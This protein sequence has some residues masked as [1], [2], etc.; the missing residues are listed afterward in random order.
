ML[1]SAPS[2]YNSL[3]TFSLV[4]IKRKNIENRQYVVNIKAIG[5]VVMTMFYY[6]SFTGIPVSLSMWYRIGGGHVDTSI[7]R[8]SINT[9]T[10]RT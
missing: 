6:F 4:Y 1:I 2:I 10:L 9:T 8:K 7:L 5:V 3:N